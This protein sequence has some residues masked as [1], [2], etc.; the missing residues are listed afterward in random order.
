MSF[1][2]AAHPY[3]VKPQG[4]AFFASPSS[5]QVRENGLGPSFHRL[6]DETLIDLLSF[7]SI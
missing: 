5:L 6:K 4:N 7:F 2:S 3:G 1:T